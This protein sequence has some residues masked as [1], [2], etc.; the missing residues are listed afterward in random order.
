MADPRA[1]SE[2]L[3]R[4]LERSG[5]GQ[6]ELPPLAKNPNEGGSWLEKLVK[7]LTSHFAPQ[8]SSADTTWVVLLLKLIAVVGL[9]FILVAI[10]GVLVRRLRA[11]ARENSGRGPGTRGTVDNPVD[12]AR[13]HLEAAL[14]AGDLGEAARL[15]WKLSLSRCELPASIT[16]GETQ[17]FGR[18]YPLMFGRVEGQAALT[19]YQELDRRLLAFEG[20]QEPR[21]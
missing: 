3:D 17:D 14:A 13:K 10:V 5:A 9:S 18:F 2:I 4:L 7:W 16:P 21:P 1:P 19:E 20:G 11:A 12:L 15:R 8:G 6:F